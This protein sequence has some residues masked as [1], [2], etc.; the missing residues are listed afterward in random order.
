MKKIKEIWNRIKKW[1]KYW[2]FYRP[3]IK[4]LLTSK[5]LTNKSKRN[6]FIDAIYESI[7]LNERMMELEK[8]DNNIFTHIKKKDFEELEKVDPKIIERNIALNMLNYNIQ[9]IDEIQNINLENKEKNEDQNTG[10]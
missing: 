9:S 4:K 2:F 10:S 7:L 6:Y 1:I 8:N 3:L 5:G